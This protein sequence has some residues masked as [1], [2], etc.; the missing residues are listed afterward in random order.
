MLPITTAKR[1]DSTVKPF[2]RGPCKALQKVPATGS[3]Q[4]RFYRFKDVP[5]VLH[6]GEIEKVYHK[7]G[8]GK[9][10]DNILYICNLLFKEVKRTQNNSSSF[11]FSSPKNNK[12]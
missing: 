4:I 9:R 2:Y 7:P 11:N 8:C 10:K 6:Y 3:P 12:K 1:F 5:E